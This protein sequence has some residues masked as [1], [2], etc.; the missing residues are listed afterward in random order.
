MK[1]PRGI[2]WKIKFYYKLSSNEQGRI[3]FYLV[4]FA[5]LSFFRAIL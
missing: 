5:Q 1:I 3:D 2:V 4:V